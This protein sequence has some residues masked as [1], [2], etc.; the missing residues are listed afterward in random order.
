MCSVIYGHSLLQYTDIIHHKL[1]IS[2]PFL[3]SFY[4]QI[5]LFLFLYKA[6]RGRALL[7]KTQVLI[8]QTFET[9]HCSIIHNSFMVQFK[10]QARY[11]SSFLNSWWSKRQRFDIE[12]SS[13]CLTKETMILIF[14]LQTFNQCE[15][16]KNT[17]KQIVTSQLIWIY[18][19]YDVSMLIHL[20]LRFIYTLYTLFIISTFNSMHQTCQGSYLYSKTPSQTT[21]KALWNTIICNSKGN[22]NILLFCSTRRITK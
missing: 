2:K 13:H 8:C 5:A 10:L 7:L 3:I 6:N 15:F 16:V 17:N 1:T 19:F 20:F 22:E 4:N 9:F 14:W 12:I 11:I 21:I 18:N